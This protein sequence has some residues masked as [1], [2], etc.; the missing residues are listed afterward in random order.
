V[1]PHPLAK[2][3]SRNANDSDEDD[4][5]DTG[6]RGGEGQGGPDGSDARRTTLS[7]FLPTSRR[8]VQVGCRGYD[9]QEGGGRHSSGHKYVRDGQHVGGCLK[10]VPQ[11]SLYGSCQMMVMQ[12]HKSAKLLS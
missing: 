12:G 9:F 7:K 10:V 2:S 5:E 1:Q 6:R 3:F 4:D 11:A 8:L